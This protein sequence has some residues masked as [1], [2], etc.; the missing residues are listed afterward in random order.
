MFVAFLVLLAAISAQEVEVFIPTGHTHNLLNAVYSPDGKYI[1]SCGSN[2][3]IKIWDARSRRAIHTIEARATEI[4]FSADGKR[5]LSSGDRKGMAIWELSSGKAIKIFGNINDAWGLGTTGVHTPLESSSAVFTSDGKHILS[6][7]NTNK[8]SL[9]DIDS[10]KIIRKTAITGQMPVYSPDGTKILTYLDNNLELWDAAS[11]KEL[12]S[13]TGHTDR[14]TS[15][16]FS[17]DGK[18]LISSSVDKT[19]RIW[20]TET[21][22]ELR[23]LTGHSERVNAVSFS[24]DGKKILSIGSIKNNNPNDSFIYGS[25]ELIMW[26]VLTGEK[27]FARIH[28][29]DTH[30]EAYIRSANFSPDGRTYITTS[31]GRFFTSRIL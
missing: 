16:A 7:D 4:V 8:V 23:V 9:W 21:G 25:K 28:Y 3:F 2:G 26:D 17:A 22:R 11:E 12:R 1:V 20:D 27:L 18:M 19:V 31:T 5:F 13:F 10:G 15:A 14:V 24:T 29:P 6:W 30:T